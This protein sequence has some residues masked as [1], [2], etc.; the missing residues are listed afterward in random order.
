MGAK[1]NYKLILNSAIK[2]NKDFYPISEDQKERLKDE[3]YK[4]ACDVDERCKKN[5]IKIFL[6]GG[7]L[8]GA[9]RHM[10]FIPWDDDIDFGTFREDYEK[11]KKV[12]EDEFADTYELR[13]PNSPYPNGN[14]FMQIFK[15]NTVLRNID[16]DNPLQPHEISI[17][18]F[19][20]DS[21]PNNR[22]ARKAKGIYANFLMAIASCVM[23]YQY[24]NKLLRET[25]CKFNDARCLLAIR[26]CIGRIFSFRTAEK[27]FDGVDTCIA[28]SKKAKCITSATG[29]FH[30]FGEIYDTDVFVPL[31]TLLFREH[32]FYAPSQYK[33]YL[34]GNYGKDYMTPPAENARESHFIS[35][36]KL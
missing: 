28:S 21:V 3:L 10:D 16:S 31:T 19:P 36:I 11:I 26:D 30:Y 33:V 18:I 32:K 2:N 14:R 35:E 22:V 20:Y 25:M 4:M 23:E 6:T 1:L 24:P 17:D 27:W 13:C 8:L 12:F 9:V 7:S 34:E 29:R 15:K 5:D